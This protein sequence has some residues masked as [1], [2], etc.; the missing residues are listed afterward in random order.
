MSCIGTKLFPK[1]DLHS[2]YHQIRACEGDIPK[3]TF[4]TYKGHYEFLVMPFGLTNALSTFQR[5]MNAIFKPLLR[6]FV[7]V[8]YFMIS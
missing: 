5:L 7:I 6:R 1:L 8:F 4:R 2:N 3:T